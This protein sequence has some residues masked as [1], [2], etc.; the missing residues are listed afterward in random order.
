MRQKA[1][2]FT[3]KFPISLILCFL[4]CSLF[5]TGCESKT[6]GETHRENKKNERAGHSGKSLSSTKSIKLVGKEYFEK[7]ID[8]LDDE[9]IL[10]LSSDGNSS[11]LK[12]FHLYNGEIEEIMETHK[13]IFDVSVDPSGKYLLVVQSSVANQMELS[14]ITV[15][16]E[17]VYTV[18][19][20]GVDLIHEWNFHENGKV[21]VGSFYEDW[22]FR[23][24]IIDVNKKLLEELVI[25]Q[26]FARWTGENEL[27]YINWDLENPSI[28]APLMSINNSGK[29]TK[30]LDSVVSFTLSKNIIVTVNEKNNEDS[31][32]FE[33]FNQT[34]SPIASFSLPVLKGYSEWMIPSIEIDESYNKVITIAPHETAIADTYKDGFS[35]IQF[36]WK[37]GKKKVI[38]DNVDFSNIAC[39]PSGDLCLIGEQLESVVD[40]YESKQSKIYLE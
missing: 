10:F 33:I 18:T 5:I 26:P 27:S 16:G 15:E 6:G 39:A 20:P 32:T 22:S 38:L 30:L 37:E 3:N 9:R 23:S 25:D 36:N 11:F 35:L 2:V 40:I 13:P 8:W 24:Y 28:S 31:A 29:K 34:F 7:S 17:K 1:R 19:L 4:F 14:I 12:S 21:Y